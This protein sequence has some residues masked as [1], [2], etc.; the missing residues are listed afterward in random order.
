MSLYNCFIF[1]L[2]SENA[3]Y[4]VKDDIGKFLVR[5]R[6]TAFNAKFLSSILSRRTRDFC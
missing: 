5:E 1:P 6:F 2:L 3:K 4:A